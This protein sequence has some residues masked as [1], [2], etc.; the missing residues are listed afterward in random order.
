[1]EK[2]KCDRCG[3]EFNKED[4][5]YYR[6]KYI[7]MKRQ[8]KPLS[9]IF[10]GLSDDYIDLCEDCSAKVKLFIDNYQG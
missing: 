2:T 8:Y 4:E 9:N 6:P 7:V 10:K 1:M 3:K 5:Q